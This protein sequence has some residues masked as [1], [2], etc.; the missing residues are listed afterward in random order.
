MAIYVQK[1][2]EGLSGRYVAFPPLLSHECA[3]ADFA[4]VVRDR[5]LHQ[6]RQVTH[7]RSGLH[8]RF[9]AVAK[10]P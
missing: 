2:A 6:R 9:W 10:T 3:A 1:P 5:L 8:I 4:H 7:P